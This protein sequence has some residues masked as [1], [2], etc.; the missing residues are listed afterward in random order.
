MGDKE[1]RTLKPDN[2]FKEF[3]HK[4]EREEIRIG[5]SYSIEEGLIHF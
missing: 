3:Y 4:R 2:H 5:R 1:L